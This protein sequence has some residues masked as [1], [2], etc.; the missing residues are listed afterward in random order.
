MYAVVETGGKQY[1]VA[2][3]EKITVEKINAQ[4]GQ[5]VELNKVL[6]IA[7]NDAFTFGKPI[8]EGA[9]VT[10]TVLEQVR[11]NRIKVVKFKR[12]KGYH[13][14]QGHRQFLTSLKIEKI[15]K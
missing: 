14:H 4:V 13:L 10:A 8:V 9:K 7:E 12:R 6:L 2:E 5:Q 1:R 3:N 15:V 11:G